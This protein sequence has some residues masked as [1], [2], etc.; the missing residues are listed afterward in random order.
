MGE[1]FTVADCYLFTVLNWT[2]FTK[3]DLGRWP[4]LK[5]Y[6]DRIGQRPHVVEALKAEGLAK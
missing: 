3:I 4:E 1:Q 2:G 5:R 6:F